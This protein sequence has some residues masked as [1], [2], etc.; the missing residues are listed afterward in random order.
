MMQFKIASLLMAC[1][2]ASCSRPMPPENNPLMEPVKALE[3]AK[4]LQ[5]QIMQQVGQQKRQPG[6]LEAAEK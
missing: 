2:L 5:S 1:V 3:H 4:A 6:Q